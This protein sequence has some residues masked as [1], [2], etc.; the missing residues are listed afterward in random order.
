MTSGHARRETVEIV[1]I[2]FNG[3]GLVHAAC[4][5][6]ASRRRLPC[7]QRTKFAHLSI[8]HPRIARYCD[9]CLSDLVN[10]RPRVAVATTTAVAAHA[11]LSATAAITTT[12]AIGTTAAL[13]TRAVTRQP[14]PTTAPTR[15]PAIHHP[16]ETLTRPSRLLIRSGSTFSSSPV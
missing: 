12:T 8:S 15:H 14:K 16:T 13:V 2:G 6:T 9:S 5:L 7:A 4:S 3:I 1:Q 11:A 10:P